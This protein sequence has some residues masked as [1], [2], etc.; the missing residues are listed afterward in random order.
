MTKK[1]KLKQL[2][3]IKKYIRDL[4][5][6]RIFR[7]LCGRDENITGVIIDASKS[8]LSIQCISDF[9]LDGYAI[10][11]FDDYDNIQH[12]KLERAQKKILIAEKILP[13]EF[14]H[15]KSI[16]L[17]EWKDIFSALK[18]YDLHVC[19]QNVKK[20]YLDFWIGPIVKIT[21]KTVSIHN[22][23]PGGRLDSQ[24]TAI[25]F[26]TIR[27]VSF[28]DRYST[29]FRKYLKLPKEKGVR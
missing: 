5:L 25:K 15:N 12:S 9:M 1:S 29:T 7:T 27:T 28:G 21:A 26:D 10:I 16:P 18:D 22:Y 20:E 24:P 6:V 2:D 19:I 14:G 13:F 23:D 8:F 17:T 4:T 11:K 3:V